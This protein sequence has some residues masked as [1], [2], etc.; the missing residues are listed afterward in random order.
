MSLYRILLVEPNLELG[1]VLEEY[2]VRNSMEVIRAPDARQGLD[3]ARRERPDLIV[4]E[5]EL[6]AADGPSFVRALRVEPDLREIPF[7]MLSADM[8]PEHRLACLDSG[9]DDY[10][11]KPFSMKELVLRCQRQ[12]VYHRRH[13]TSELSGDLSRFKSTD[14]LQMLETNQ[15]T[16]VLYVEGNVS[17]EIHLLDGSIC[18]GFAGSARGED[19]IYRLIPVRKGRFYF[20]RT[21]IR[22]N[23]QVVYSTTEFMMEAFRLH[24]EKEHQPARSDGTG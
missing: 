24:D 18:G 6:P 8:S 20:I 21:N 22:S 7:V 13:E 23:I 16:G 1:T 17:G 19:A 12:I 14:I 10:L 4:S 5:N 11:L 3:A 9:A 15:A 2:L